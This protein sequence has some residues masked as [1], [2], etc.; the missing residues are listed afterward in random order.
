MVKVK[1]FLCLINL[2]LRYED[3]WWSGGI[4]PPFLMSAIDV[5]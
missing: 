2:E 4:P 3:I 5:D 1:L